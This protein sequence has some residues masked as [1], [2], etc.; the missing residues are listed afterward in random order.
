MYEFG[1]EKKRDK[2]HRRSRARKKDP[3]RR[4]TWESGVRRSSVAVM[5]MN[6]KK[7]EI[8]LRVFLK[9]SNTYIINVPG[10]RSILTL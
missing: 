8:R 7:H 9:I 1:M 10:K 3:P 6:V 2:N 5:A 4:S